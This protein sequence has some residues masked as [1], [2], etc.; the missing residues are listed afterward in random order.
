MRVVVVL[1]G[2]PGAGKSTVARES[3]LKFFDRD[4]PVW[5]SERQFTSALA[6]LAG[7]TGAR[8]VVIRSAATSSARR[9]VA[10]MVGATHTFLVSAPDDV[11]VQRVRKRGRDVPRELAGVKSWLGSFDDADGVRGFPGWPAVFGEGIGYTSRRW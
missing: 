5:L 1:C 9:R 7:D 3:G 8:A 4:D 6:E 10:R 2:P 11:L